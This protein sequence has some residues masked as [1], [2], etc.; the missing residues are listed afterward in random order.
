MMT[1]FVVM[2]LFA[3]V[4]PLAA[5]VV[6][7]STDEKRIA[8]LAAEIDREHPEGRRSGMRLLRDD[9][10]FDGTIRLTLKGRWIKT[11]SGELLSPS[12]RALEDPDT[13]LSEICLIP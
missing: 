11:T 13:I 8:Y 7:L 1:P 3:L 9:D 6:D 12:A 2:L 5:A 10:P 4:I